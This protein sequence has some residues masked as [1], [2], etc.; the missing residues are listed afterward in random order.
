MVFPED[1]VGRHPAPETQAV[2]PVDHTVDADHYLI[3]VQV[4]IDPNLEPVAFLEQGG[5]DGNGQLIAFAVDTK[6][7]A[8]CAAGIQVA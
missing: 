7:E 6:V 1:Q 3:L 5:R 2:G 8:A 4:E